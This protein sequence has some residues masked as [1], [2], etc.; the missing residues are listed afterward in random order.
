MTFA[1]CHKGPLH[2]QSND[3]LD[4]APNAEFVG[5]PMHSKR[6]DGMMNPLP[7]SRETD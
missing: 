7:F 2:D 5:A 1:Y 6:L 3:Y 4:I